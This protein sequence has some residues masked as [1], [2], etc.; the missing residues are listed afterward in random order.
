MDKATTGVL[1]T[2]SH[3][4]VEPSSVTLGWLAG[5]RQVWQ[6]TEGPADERAAA[7]DAFARI[8][9]RYPQPNNMNARTTYYRRGFAMDDG[10][11]AVLYD[12]IGRAAGGVMVTL[13]Q[14]LFEQLGPESSWALVVELLP[15]MHVSRLDLAADASGSDCL[16]PAVLFG[17]LPAARSRS[18]LDNRVLTVDAAGGEKLT[19]GSRASERYLRVYVKGDR[20]RH[21]V[22]LKQATAGAAMVRLAAG[23]PIPKVWAEEYGR[24]VAWR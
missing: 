23:E 5:T 9:D 12:G 17:L 19:I 14:G 24:I 10:C 18:R 7:W 15:G 13:R 6:S 16:S 8:R 20:I 21:E 3:T 22:E 4:W 2:R 1:P 11:A